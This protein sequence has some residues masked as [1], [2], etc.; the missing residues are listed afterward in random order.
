M[1][2]GPTVVVTGGTR[3]LGREVSL[4]FARH[5]YR[6][7][8]LYQRDAEAAARL[9]A[10]LGA[11]KLSGRSYRHDVAEGGAEA[12]VWSQP[13]ITEASALVLIHNA[14]AAFEPKPL[15]LLHWEDF[16]SGLDVAL[17]GAWLVTLGLLRPMLKKGG[18][19]I[20]TVSTSAL[21][22][23]PPKGFSAYLA[24]KGALRAL[25]ASLAAEYRSRG[26]RVFAVAPGF[27]PTPLTQRW[28][29]AFREAALRSSGAAD[30]ATVARAIRK[31]VEDATLP[32]RGESY[33]V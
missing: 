21:S 22:S 30:P 7:L 9:D 17:K 12:A 28:H 2:A 29:A 19:T 10:D 5:G 6:V 26:I 25:T 24:A 18:G 20:V 8:A 31:L 3:G 23:T 33:D 14:S 32:A 13:E 15:H 16:T 1:G 4:E 27:M 11:E